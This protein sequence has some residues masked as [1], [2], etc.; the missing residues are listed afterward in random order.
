MIKKEKI[1]ALI[2]LLA[3]ATLVLIALSSWR[4]DK[5]R[6]Q[7][8]E[9][10]EAYH[11][12]ADIEK[13][14]L[15]TTQ[16]S[17]GAFAKRPENQGNASVVPYFSCF[18][19]LALIDGDEKGEY[20]EQVRDYIDWHFAHLNDK[21]E[22]YNGVA[23]TIYNYDV[24]IENGIVTKEQSTG[25]YDSTDS[26]AAT[27]LSLVYGFARQYE[28]Q[29]YL[30]NHKTELLAVSNAMLETMNHGLSYSKPDYKI[31]FLMDN[32]EVYAGCQDMSELIT[33]LKLDTSGSN[34]EEFVELKKQL[35]KNQKV[36]RKNIQGLWN[37]KGQYYEPAVGTSGEPASEFEWEEF[38]PSAASQLFPVI[39]G[40]VT[41][42]DVYSKE[43]YKQFSSVYQWEELEHYYDG[44]ASFYWS[45]LA[46]A[47][48]CMGDE[49]RVNTYIKSYCKETKIGHE[50]PLYNADSAWMIRSC[51]YMANTYKEKPIGLIQV[52]MEKI[53]RLENQL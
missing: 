12:Q 8:N 34:Q 33:M 42:Q 21:K 4:N 3:G 18:T 39:F 47:G 30:E 1:Y 48:A 25:E 11:Q 13:K 53:K 37:Q 40:V 52:C 23:G 9:R 45:M 35:V 15:I 5:L 20:R 36:L 50:K 43:V 2:V 46:Y 19:A 51:E 16:L 38:Y 31:K 32:A 10:A 44:K 7:Y 17:N 49:D 22:D 41:P 27:F 24:V 14:W 29:E 6:T 28:E 26:Y